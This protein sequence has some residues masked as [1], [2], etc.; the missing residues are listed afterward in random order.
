MPKTNFILSNKLLI[1]SY[2]IKKTTGPRKCFIIQPAYHSSSFGMNTCSPS[3]NTCISISSSSLIAASEGRPAVRSLGI[4]PLST[5]RR[6]PARSLSSSTLACSQSPCVCASITR[7]SL[8]SLH[9]G[10][11]KDNWVENPSRWICSKSSC[12]TPGRSLS[13]VVSIPCQCMT[14]EGVGGMR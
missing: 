14:P 7:V 4:G 3:G 1:D 10:Q 5:L 6:F 2:T 9:R 11:R 13:R 8:H 12:F